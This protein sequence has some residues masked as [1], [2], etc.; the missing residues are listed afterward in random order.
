MFA[1]LIVGGSRHYARFVCTEQE[2]ISQQFRLQD[3]HD[4]LLGRIYT[5]SEIK[6]GKLTSGGLGDQ[7]FHM[8]Q[9]A[10]LVQMAIANCVS[11]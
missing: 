7:F 11:R 8:R 5:A 1:Y 6:G 9:T 2:T 3:F 4:L 10:R